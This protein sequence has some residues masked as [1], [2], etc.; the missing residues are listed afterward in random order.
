[1][2]LDANVLLYALISQ[3]PQ[4]QRAST[5]LKEQLA[6][7][8]G[9][10]LPWPSMLA[11]VRIATNRRVLVEPLSGAQAWQAMSTLLDQPN[12]W[13]PIAGAAHRGIFAELMLRHAPIADLVMDLSLTALAVEHGLQVA[14][15]DT[16]FARFPEARWVNPLQLGSGAGA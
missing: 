7:R 10:A 16:D 15:S 1:M 4:H 3:F 12:V 2:L 11:F 9:V 5:W 8:R 6:S 14:S 13:I